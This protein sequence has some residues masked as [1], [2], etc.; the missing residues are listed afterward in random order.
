MTQRVLLIAVDSV[1]ID[2]LGHERPESV[3]SESEFLFPRGRRGELLMLPDAP[4]EGALVETD[5]T[6]GHDRG[7]IECAITYTAHFTGQDAVA[8]HGLL[9]GLGLREQV[10]K[11]MVHESNL[12]QLYPDACLANAIFPVHLPFFG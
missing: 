4:A 9:Q 5:V 12:F 8:R 2:P 7:A 6:G 1:G 3:Y 11:E 10:L